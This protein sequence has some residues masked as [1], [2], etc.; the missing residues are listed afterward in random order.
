MFDYNPHITGDRIIPEK[1]QKLG[2]DDCSPGYW[3]KPEEI[4]CKWQLPA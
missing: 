3:L 4:P 1:N 2:F